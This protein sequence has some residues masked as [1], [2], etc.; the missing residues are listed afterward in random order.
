MEITEI[1]GDAL[2]YPFNNI[3]SLVIYLVLGI[4]LGL[5]F[6]ATLGGIIFGASA[7][8]IIALLGSATLGIIVTLFIGFVIAGYG[9]DI[10]EYGINRNDGAPEVDFVGQFI[11][12]IKL[13]VVEFIYLLI[14]ILISSI[15]AIIFQHWI[16]SIISLILSIIFGFALLMGECRLA[17][18]GELGY[19]LAIPDAIADISKVGLVKVILFMIVLVVIVVVLFAIG[20]FVSRW[21]SIV[22]GLFLGI[23]GVYISFFTARATGLLYSDV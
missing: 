2:G 3:K 10:V 8:N 1:F 12:G 15:L 18:T 17:K 9:L 23:I 21:N 19:A 4:I 13:F 22:G 20:M 6:G 14:P 11:K 16:T 5:V 7:G